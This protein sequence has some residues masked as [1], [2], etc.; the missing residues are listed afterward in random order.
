MAIAKCFGQWKMQQREELVKKGHEIMRKQKS[1]DRIPAKTVT[2][3]KRV[4]SPLFVGLLA[5]LCDLVDV[6]VIYFCFFLGERACNEEIKSKVLR[7]RC[8]GVSALP[9]CFFFSSTRL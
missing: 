7:G 4:N 3:R 5:L 8:F 2:A 6:V 9:P 1:Q